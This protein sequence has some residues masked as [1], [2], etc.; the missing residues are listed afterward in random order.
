MSIYDG[1]CHLVAKLYKN[2]TART[3][4]LYG[5]MNHFQIV[6]LLGRTLIKSH[7]DIECLI[8]KRTIKR[9]ILLSRECLKREERASALMK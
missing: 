7:F 4:S 1:L 6:Q 2:L 3:R 8:I 5:D 9:T